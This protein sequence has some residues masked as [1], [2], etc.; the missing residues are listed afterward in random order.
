M[1]V[2]E[3]LP[4]LCAVCIPGLN[5]EFPV[6]RVDEDSYPNRVHVRNMVFFELFPCHLH[7]FLCCF[8]PPRSFLSVSL[9]Q[10]KT[11][12]HAIDLMT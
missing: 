1:P 10:E 11:K 2:A 3:K 9:F 5:D 6:C 7:D 8:T 12:M 4:S